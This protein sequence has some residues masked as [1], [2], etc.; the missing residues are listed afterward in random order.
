M[1]RAKFRR[2][3]PGVTVP[4]DSEDQVKEAFRIPMSDEL[5]GTFVAIVFSAWVGSKTSRSSV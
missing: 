1:R 2:D 3:E 4:V 5:L